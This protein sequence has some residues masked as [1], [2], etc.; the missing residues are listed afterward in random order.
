M[1]SQPAKWNANTKQQKLPRKPLRWPTPSPW[2]R[3]GPCQWRS[4][5]HLQTL[6]LAGARPGEMLALRRQDVNTK[7]KRQRFTP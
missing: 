6:L 1:A 7:W 5:A 4:A 3:C 2:A